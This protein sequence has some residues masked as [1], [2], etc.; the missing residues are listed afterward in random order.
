[1]LALC[2]SVVLFS[3]I[4]AALFLLGEGAFRVL[5]FFFLREGK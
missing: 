1:M 5:D 4:L 3:V 2:L